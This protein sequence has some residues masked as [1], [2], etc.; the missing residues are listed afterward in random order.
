MERK[1]GI[2]EYTLIMK[3]I[4]IRQIKCPHSNDRLPE[5]LHNFLQISIVTLF[6][7]QRLVVFS[8]ESYNNKIKDRYNKTIITKILGNQD[9]ITPVTLIKKGRLIEST[10][11]F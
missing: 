6:I 5:S 4:L 11:L 9:N 7:N 3:I 2:G 10:V 8:R 1:K